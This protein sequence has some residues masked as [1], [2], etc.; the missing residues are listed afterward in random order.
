RQLNRL[1]T[2]TKQPQQRLFAS[3]REPE[4]DDGSDALR[5]RIAAFRRVTAGELEQRGE[6]R[7]DVLDG[8]VARAAAPLG[9]FEQPPRQSETKRQFTRAVDR[10]DDMPDLRGCILR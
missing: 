8:G 3:R 9:A 1:R 4:Q 2:F 6:R 5:Q 7:L 10:I